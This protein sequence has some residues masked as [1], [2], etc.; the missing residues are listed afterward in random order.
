[1]LNW[2]LRYAPAIAALE[3][4]GADTVLDIGA[5][6]HGLSWYWSGSVVQTDLSFVAIEEPLRTGTAS[7]VVSTAERLPFQDEA[8]DAVLSI[9]MLEH[10]P[11]SIRGGAIKEAFRVGR[12][13]VIL[14]FPTG[15]H[16]ELADRRLAA[17]LRLARKDRPTWLEEH[18][19]QQEYPSVDWVTQQA[20]TEWRLKHVCRDMN[21]WVQTGVVLAELTPGLRLLARGLERWGR[22]H[23][24]PRWLNKGPSYRTFMV[25]VRHSAVDQPLS[26]MKLS[27]RA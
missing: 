9:D 24:F 25:F 11:E 27:A 3:E 16:A 5:G 26:R 15:R 23:T 17:L 8:F 19:S 13:T 21:G 2:L 10:L 18:L 14:V 6:S 7:F 22:E 12:R 4:C 20:P 1:V